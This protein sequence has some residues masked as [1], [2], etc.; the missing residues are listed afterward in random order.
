M[1]LTQA[2][3]FI[4]P[5]A[6]TQ[7]R[8]GLDRIREL[9]RRLGDPQNDLRFV[10]VAGTN[11]KGS[12]CTMLASILQQAG[13]TTGLYT[14]PHLL[15]IHERMRV[16]G[17]A[18]TSKELIRLAEEVKP[19]VDQMADVPSEFERITAM[20][21]LYFKKRGCQIVVLE[22]GL[23]GRLDSTNIIPPPDA[24]VITNIGLEHTEYLGNTLSKIA[25]EKAGIIKEN[26]PTILYEQSEE[27]TS[28]VQRVCLDMHA[29]LFVTERKQVQLC[30]SGLKGQ[31]ISYRER[32]NLF[33]P[34]LGTY[35]IQ[36]A[37][38]VLD[39]VDVLNQKQGYHISDQSI[40][41]GLCKVQWPGRFEVLM[42]RPL[43][44]VDGAHNPNGVEHLAASI[45]EYLPDRKITFVMG[46]MA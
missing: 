36:N 3:E 32:K 45:R 2:L 31:Q 46:V 21:L 6:I 20:A 28:V 15:S 5:T 25:G 11:G 27:V 17:D 8:L 29:P 42:E 1:N 41:N 43:V 13:Y 26:T 9:M 7:T 33:L 22:V 39:T 14:S 18:I 4:Q 38:V 30:S 19:A 44:L 12:V 23:G 35:Q 16:N 24:A 40:V 34:L 37:A 10:H